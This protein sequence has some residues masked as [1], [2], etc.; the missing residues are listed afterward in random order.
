MSWRS[1]SKRDWDGVRALLLK[2]EALCVP[3][4]ARFKDQKGCSVFVDADHRGEIKSCFLVSAYGLVLPVLPGE[5]DGSSGFPEILSS[6][7]PAVRSIMG[8]AAWVEK[9]EARIPLAPSARV[10]YFLMVLPKSGR[11]PAR[12]KPGGI[13]I[14]RASFSDAERLY[15]LQKAYE[16][17]EVIINPSYFSEIQCLK[18]LKASLRDEIMFLAEK[19]G[20]PVSK[21][22]TNARGYGVDQIGGVYTVP[23]ARGKGYAGAVME[24]LLDAIFSEKST[25]SLFVKKKN[26]PAIQ[27]YKR[28]GFETKSDY[29]IS[30]YGI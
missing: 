25:A 4:S 5:D 27:L 1:A 2:N 30:Y 28:M 29:L 10:E 24:A 8:T 26:L 18:L 20:R 6:L 14:R 16:L 21:A 3:A 7:R 12:E 15:P 17:E 11:M 19:S 9:V 22:G 13:S 23:E